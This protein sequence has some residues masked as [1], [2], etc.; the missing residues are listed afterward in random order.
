MT[1]SDCR[2]LKMAA[3]LL[4]LFAQS[5]ASGSDGDLLFVPET[6][7]SQPDVPIAEISFSNVD[8]LES[9]PEDASSVSVPKIV[10]R[11]G[12]EYLEGEIAPCTVD[13]GAGRNP[14]DLGLPTSRRNRFEPSIDGIAELNILDIVLPWVDTIGTHL[15][16]RGVVQ[17]KSTRCDRYPII[18]PSF[19][20]SGEPEGFATRWVNIQ[21]YHC[22]VDFVVS[23]YIVGKGSPILTVSV[24]RYVLYGSE[25]EKIAEGTSTAE[26]VL[27]TPRGRIGSAEELWSE[28]LAW[29]ANEYEGKELVLF[30]STPATF[31]VESWIATAVWFVQKTEDN[32]IRVVPRFIDYAINDAVKRQLIIPL[33]E[34][35]ELTKQTIAE[36][37]ALTDGRI[38]VDTRLPLAITDAHDL[39]EYYIKAGAVYGA[40][41]GATVLP[42]PAP[43]EDYAVSPAIPAG[44]GTTVS[45]APVPSG[46]MI[47]EPEMVVYKDGR[48]YLS[49]VV[50]PC[51]VGGDVNRDPCEPRVLPILEIS[52]LISYEFLEVDFLRIILSEEVD[53]AGTHLVVR[54]IVQ[55]NSTRCDYYPIIL[56]NFAAD[57]LKEALPSFNHQYH[58]HCF[59]DVAVSEYIVGEGPPV[60]TVSVNKY[61][62]TKVL[63]DERGRDPEEIANNPRSWTAGAYEGKEMVVFL[64]T[65]GTFAVE[66]WIA[67]NVWFVQRTTENLIQAVSLS[68]DLAPP[69][70]KEQMI[71][72]LQELVQRVK[73]AVAE[74]NMLTNGRLGIDPRLPLLITDAY[75]LREY[76]ENAGAVYG[77]VE[78]A[79]VLPPPVPGEGDPAPPTIPTDEEGTVS[80]APVPGEETPVTPPTDDAGLP[81]D[82]VTTTVTSTS[83]TIEVATTAVVPTSE[84][85]STVSTAPVETTTTTTEPATTETASTT[86]TTVATGTPGGEGGLPEPEDGLS[87]EE[88][89]APATTLSGNNNIPEAENTT[90]PV[91]N[92]GEDQQEGHSDPDQE[93]GG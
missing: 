34:L 28:P 15:V 91:D 75:D 8:E 51:T 33:Q 78:G 42:P 73:Q 16:V 14:C 45:S 1:V 4:A 37:D 55:D 52:E 82:E 72:P 43:G 84:V 54:G 86:T 19:M 69:H 80:S 35:V 31:A 76:Y 57:S 66:T 89:S 30:L 49:G 17:D 22:F 85:V 18:V 93:P 27:A 53:F 58:Y 56:P 44:E 25:L 26:E 60:V 67:T 24:N 40:V 5:C 13:G 9:I 29:N 46:D 92:Q 39:R 32:N 79:T 41:E 59:V 2:R 7:A 38:G 63:I 6:V 61:P 88:Q 47:S 77:A 71:M 11:N 90:L 36:R 74:R 70:I 50:P 68:R 87:G 64:A 83:T 48:E 65:P 23:E 10:Y 20:A 62:I 3:V 12:R 21:H 81:D